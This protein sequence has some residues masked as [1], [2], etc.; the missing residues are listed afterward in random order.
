MVA[1]TNLAVG[2]HR[3]LDLAGSL[4]A[5]AELRIAPQISAAENGGIYHIL[6]GTTYTDDIPDAP[7]PSSVLSSVNGGIQVFTEYIMSIY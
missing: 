4:I 2:A 3:I 1:R 5:Y 7:I 6:I